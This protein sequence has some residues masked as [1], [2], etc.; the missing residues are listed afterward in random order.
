MSDVK[1]NVRSAWEFPPHSLV[2]LASEYDALAAKVERL[3]AKLAQPAEAEGV[4]V[5]AEVSLLNS[6]PVGVPMMRDGK[7]T[8][9][10]GEYLV[11]HADHRAA[12]ASVTA[13]RDRLDEFSEALGRQIADAGQREMAL[14]AEVE[15]LRGMLREARPAVSAGSRK[16]GGEHLDELLDRID[17]ALAAKE[18]V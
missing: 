4:E 6:Q 12:L 8:L 2:V 15:A 7:W 16:W 18:G 11:R 1:H 3:T 10:A 14:R 17:A 5:V 9:K 13:E